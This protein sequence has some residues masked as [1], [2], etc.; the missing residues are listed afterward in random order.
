MRAGDRGTVQCLLRI[1]ADQDLIA[2]VPEDQRE[3]AAD[4]GVV[5]ADEDALVCH[6]PLLAI[7][8][9][10]TL[11]TS[12]CRSGSGSSTTNVVPRPPCDSTA[13]RA[14][15]RSRKPLLL[16]RPRPEPG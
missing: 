8:P 12:G 1:R 13:M 2:R 10:G 14:P 7:E 6:Q 9:A 11:A 3:G 4:L 15:L 16:A 5:I